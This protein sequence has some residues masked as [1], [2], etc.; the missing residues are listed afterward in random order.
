MKSFPSR[1]EPGFFRKASRS[2]LKST[3]PLILHYLDF[4]QN[5]NSEEW[6]GR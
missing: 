3:V 1:T 2:V 4:T 5:L 6:V